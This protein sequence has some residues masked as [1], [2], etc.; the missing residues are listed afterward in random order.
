MIEARIRPPQGT[1]TSP[2]ANPSTNGGIVLRDLLLPDFRAYA[3]PVPNPGAVSA[4]A[5]ISDISALF[6]KP[7]RSPEISLIP[8]I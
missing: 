5:S 6:Q 3:V 2:S 8:G 4:V 1:K 7:L